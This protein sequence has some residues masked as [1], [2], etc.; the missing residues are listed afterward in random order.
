VHTFTDSK[1]REWIVELTIGSAK[2]VRD[3]LGVDLLQLDSGTPP[4]LQRIGTDAILVCDI[5]FCL[6]KPQADAAGVTSEQFGADLDGNAVM[7]AQVAFYQELE[8]FSRGRG[9][10]ELALAVKK[11]AEMIRATSTRAVA[12]LEKIDSEKTINDALIPGNASISLPASQ[13]SIQTP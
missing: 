12:M 10:P 7:E 11:Q 3:L 8:L 2:R 5:L 4:L 9:R 1:K 13:V 6:C